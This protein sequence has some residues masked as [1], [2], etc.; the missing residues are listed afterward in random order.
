LVIKDSASAIRA[1]FGGGTGK[2]M[3]VRDYSQLLKCLDFCQT[4]SRKSS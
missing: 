2:A 3:Q 1:R 4:D